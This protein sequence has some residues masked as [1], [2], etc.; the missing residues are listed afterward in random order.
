M[1]FPNDIFVA[2]LNAVNSTHVPNRASFSGDTRH[3]FDSGLKKKGKLGA[4]AMKRAAAGAHLPTPWLFEPA[5]R[6]DDRAD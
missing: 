3:A 4:N 6:Q 5:K 2:V 1:S